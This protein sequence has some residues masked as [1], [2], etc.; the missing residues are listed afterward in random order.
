MI[1]LE[2]LV[3]GLMGLDLVMGITVLVLAVLTW[4]DFAGSTYGKAFL[5]FSLGWIF[6][7]THAVGEL[8]Y[9]LGMMEE[10]PSLW[11]SAFVTLGVITVSISYYLIY[12]D[13]R[14]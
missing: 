8:E 1:S 6:I 4:R 5:T 12:Q 3:A 10:F 9:S 2:M 14:A 7:L 13:S 11:S